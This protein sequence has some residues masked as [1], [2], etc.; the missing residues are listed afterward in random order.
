MLNAALLV[1]SASNAESPVRQL[2]GLYS[3]GATTPAAMWSIKTGQS[4]AAGSR[5]VGAPSRYRCVAR[6]VLLVC[7]SAASVRART[8][9][10]DDGARLTASSP[11]GLQCPPCERVH[12]SPRRPSRLRCRGGIVRGVCNCCPVSSSFYLSVASFRG[13]GGGSLRTPKDCEV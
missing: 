9:S 4:E 3:Y 8:P 5:S 12:C 11:L 6:L 2:R 10:S 13:T 7:V 1:G